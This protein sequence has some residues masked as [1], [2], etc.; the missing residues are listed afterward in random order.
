MNSLINY[1]PVINHIY[2]VCMTHRYFEIVKSMVFNR[3]SHEAETKLIDPSEI[4]GGR[5]LKTLIYE[6]EECE[7]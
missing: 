2:A 4:Y 7:V 1:C 3:T 6:L 5:G